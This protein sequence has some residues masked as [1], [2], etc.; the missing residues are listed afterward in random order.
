VELFQINGKLVFS[1]KKLMVVGLNH[2][3]QNLS[4]LSSG[5]YL[6]VIKNGAGEKIITKLIK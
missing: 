4:F 5:I 2:I 6:L 1:Q 3:D